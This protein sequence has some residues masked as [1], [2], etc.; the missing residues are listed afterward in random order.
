[1]VRQP[2]RCSSCLGLCTAQLPA[3]H[4]PAHKP[5]TAPH[6]SREIKFKAFTIWPHHLRRIIPHPFHE[7]H[8]HSAWDMRAV[9]QAAVHSLLL[10]TLSNWA[11]RPHT[12]LISL[13]RHGRL[14]FL[15]PFYFLPISLT[16]DLAFWPLLH[17]HSL[18]GHLLQPHSHSIYEIRRPYLH[19]WSSLSSPNSTQASSP[20]LVTSTCIH[21]SICPSVQPTLLRIT[22]LLVVSFLI[23]Q[24]YLTYNIL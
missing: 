16:S 20:L 2:P 15:G 10:E 17:L 11:S 24:I 22:S 18:P 14:P 6:C 8:C 21:L 7:L 4:F 1:M 5:S 23:I 9:R 13:T 3:C 12:L 19:L